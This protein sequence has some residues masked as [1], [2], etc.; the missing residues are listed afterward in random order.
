MDMER[1]A[2]RGKLAEAEREAETLR[3]KCEGFCRSIRYTLNCTL[4]PVSE[5][6]VAEAAAMMD[7]LAVAWAEYLS[8]S[9]TIDRLKRELF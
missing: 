8:L 4:V 2:L 1:A 7:A 5:M 6:N 3:V 9:Q